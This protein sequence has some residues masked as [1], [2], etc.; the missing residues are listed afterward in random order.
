MMLI[1]D[2]ETDDNPFV[3]ALAVYKLIYLLAV[4][5]NVDIVSDY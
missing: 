2:K 3:K 1:D 4:I 5:A